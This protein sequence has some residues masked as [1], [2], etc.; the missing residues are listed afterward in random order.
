M[1]KPLEDIVEQAIDRVI[2][3]YRPDDPVT[4]KECDS[5]LQKVETLLTSTEAGSSVLG[6]LAHVRATRI[7]L[8]AEIGDAE[9][10]I[11]QGADFLNTFPPSG[12]DYFNVQ[13]LR[14]RAL[15]ALGQHTNEIQAALDAAMSHEVRNEDFV[16]LLEGLAKRHPR[17]LESAK[18]LQEKLRYVLEQLGLAGHE[19]LPS[20]DQ[21]TTNL[22]QAVLDTAA[23]LRRINE[24]RTKAILAE[25]SG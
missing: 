24:A 17:S 13:I 16:L 8:A 9:S 10:V 6:L 1:T 2:R 20:I 5:D 18:S 25:H 19:N 3:L 12:I 22:E 15:H 11:R 14:L 7:F 21:V 23:E 4:V